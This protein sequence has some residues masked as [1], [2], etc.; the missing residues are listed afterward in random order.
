MTEQVSNVPSPTT[1]ATPPTETPATGTLLTQPIEGVTPP[2]GAPPA[3]AKP[4]E[5]EKTAEQKAADEA[6]AKAN[7][8]RANPFKADEIK[9]AEG[10]E[11]DE[12]TAKSFVDTVNKFGLPRDAIAE[13]VT[14]QSN[15]MKAAS[16]KGS[17]LWTKMQ[18]DWQA[19]IKADPAI[20]GEKLAEN[21]GAVAKVI[22]KYGTPELR[23]AFD[24]TGAGNN[25]H[26]IR[27]MAKIAK[28]LNEPGPIPGAPAVGAKDAAATLFPNQ[29]K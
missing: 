24:M 21:L 4:A 9:L 18:E 6:A 22:D 28:D 27:F 12:A 16:E 11:V 5:A 3:E 10:F 26:V 2:E 7:D 25:P 20:G 14:L 23:A 8:T 13:L 29:G 1:P 19:E 15:A 17:A